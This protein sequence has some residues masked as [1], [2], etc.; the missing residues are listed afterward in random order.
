MVYQHEEKEAVSE[1]LND[2][3][4]LKILVDN[5]WVESELQG[6]VK[7][8]L[9]RRAS[10][11]KLFRQ[12]NELIEDNEDAK[13]LARIVEMRKVYEARMEEQ[14]DAKRKDLD[15]QMLNKL[16]D[17][18]VLTYIIEKHKIIETMEDDLKTTVA[19]LKNFE[20]GLVTKLK[21]IVASVNYDE[22]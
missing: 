19:E 8:C 1:F 12:V 14:I 11:L 22:R 7:A 21:P 20:L 13:A 17:D 3:K 16:P 10:V 2:H 5:Y 6:R 4:P 18:I 15:S 9:L